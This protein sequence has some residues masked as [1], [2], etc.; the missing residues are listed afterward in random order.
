MRDVGRRLTSDTAGDTRPAAQAPRR[1]GSGR[2]REDR[3]DV[4]APCGQSRPCIRPGTLKVEPGRTRLGPQKHDPTAVAGGDIRSRLVVGMAQ[5]PS[6]IRSPERAVG[7]TVERLSGAL[8]RGRGGHLKSQKTSQQGRCLIT[9]A[10]EVRQIAAMVD[11]LSEAIDL[12]KGPRIALQ[13]V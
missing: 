3:L 9:R 7:G 4:E 11:A 5:A 13:I 6:S 1:S 8:R 2:A 12:F 10:V